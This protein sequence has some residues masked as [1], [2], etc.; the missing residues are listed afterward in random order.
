M[1]YKDI[2]FKT[3]DIL[4]PQNID[5]KK[6]SVVAC[7][8]YTSQP[9]YWQRVRSFV[10]EEASTLKLMQPEAELANTDAAEINKTMAA[11][12]QDGLLRTLSDSMI[13]VKRT[14][15]DGK[16]RQGL[17]GALD[18]ECY[19]YNKGA[20][21][22]CRATE[23]TVIDRLPPRI[24]IREGA[25]L[26][27]PH[28]MV[29]I[30]DPAFTVIEALDSRHHEFQKVYDF[31]LMEQGGH[32]QGYAIT[33]EQSIAICQKMGD[34]VGDQTNPLLYA[35]GDGNHSLATAKACYTKLKEQL[36][37]AALE[38]PARYCLVEL[39]NVHSPA[40]E[41]EPIHRIV[42][43][44]DG[45]IDFLKA[46]GLEKGA[47]HSQQIEVV[48]NGIH[49]VYSFAKETAE[50]AVG[51]LQNALD[52]YLAENNAEIDYI[53][54]EEVVD[55]LSCKDGSIGFILPNMEKSQLFT[56]VDA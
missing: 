56:T 44:A 12:M 8:Q 28:I 48:E 55:R 5:M 42:F 11:Y 54:G 3:A 15:A 49:T 43:H 24:K 36:G 51:T 47:A 33:A 14:L 9:E 35:V 31:E 13:Y 2:G 10:G 4:I 22:L 45:L 32:I 23:G 6:W 27:M 41:F 38:H 34:L 30:D 52:R 39:V 19:D 17:I 7:D 18:L 25:P 37:D 16:C 46:N 53:H 29:L 26:E 1:N 21:S 50:L 40:L 20:V